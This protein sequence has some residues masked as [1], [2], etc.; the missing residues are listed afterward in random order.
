MAATAS[1]KAN[2]RSRGGSRF[3]AW[4]VISFIVLSSVLSLAGRDQEAPRMQSQ[5]RAGILRDVIAE[6]PVGRQA[7]VCSLWVMPLPTVAALP[8]CPFLGPHDYGLA[9]LYGLALVMALATVPLAVLLKRVRVPLSRV[10]STVVLVVCAYA[11]GRTSYSDLL[12]CLALIIVAV[13]F[14]TRREPVLRALA[15]VFYGL[16]LLSHVIGILVAAVKLVA[17]ILNRVRGGRDTER[18]AIHWVQGISVG[19]ACFVYLFLNW[20][21]MQTPVWPLRDFEPHVPGPYTAEAARELLVSLRRDYPSSAAVA[22]GHWG[23]LAEPVL[24]AVGGYH[25]I[26]FDRTKVPWWEQ[27]GL[28]LVVPKKNALRSLS[29]VPPELHRS[30]ARIEGYMFLSETPNWVFYQVVRPRG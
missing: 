1:D 27:R 29:D 23:Y 30:P 13:F 16:A 6:D 5:I 28:V 10:V 4:T 15:G 20:M 9:Y 22:S 8:F 26:D 21:I 14:E 12:P 25:F 3:V 11:L 24:K 2:I 7:L 19:Y 17:I 18:R